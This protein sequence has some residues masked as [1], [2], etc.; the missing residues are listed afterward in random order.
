MQAS[1]Q[2]DFAGFRYRFDI[3]TAKNR[4]LDVFERQKLSVRMS[5]FVKRHAERTKSSPK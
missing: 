1:C 3:E 2:P 4:Q 5:M